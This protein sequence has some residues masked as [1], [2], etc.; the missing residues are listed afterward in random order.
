MEVAE[1]AEERE[2][3]REDSPVGMGRRSTSIRWSCSA[4]K[5]F[6]KSLE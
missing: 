4:V 3:E 5:R 1:T 2:R 6:S